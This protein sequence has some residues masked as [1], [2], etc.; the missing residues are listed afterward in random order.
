MICRMGVPDSKLKI[1]TYAET[2]AKSKLSAETPSASC[3]LRSN[4][5]RESTRRA[6]V[7]SAKIPVTNHA[8]F[9]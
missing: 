8:Q 5:R 7:P 9:S 1:R 2:I 6:A 4:S 3:P